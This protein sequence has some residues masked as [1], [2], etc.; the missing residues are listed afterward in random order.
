MEYQ[1]L[2]NLSDNKTTKPSKFKTKNWVKVN[3]NARGT[4]S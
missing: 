1:K 3:E 4:Y 2:V